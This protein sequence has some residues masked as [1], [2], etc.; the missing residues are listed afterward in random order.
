[1]LNPCFTED[2]T[3]DFVIIGLDIVQRLVKSE[4]I[5]TRL[6][7]L[8]TVPKGLSGRIDFSASFLDVCHSVLP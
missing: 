8:L 1:M 5:P 3:I 7:W 4:F 2:N 6:V